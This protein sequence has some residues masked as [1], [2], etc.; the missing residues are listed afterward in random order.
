MKVFMEVV[1]QLDNLPEAFEKL[2]RVS[3]WGTGNQP[4]NRLS[5]GSHSL[6][7]PNVSRCVCV[8]AR[9]P[10]LCITNCDYQG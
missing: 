6:M 9:Q 4:T 10:F 7:P 1:K 3:V 8:N 5:R 2:T